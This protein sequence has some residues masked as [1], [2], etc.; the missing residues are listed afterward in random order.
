MTALPFRARQCFVSIAGT[1][2]F[3]PL[4]LFWGGFF[5]FSFTVF[6]SIWAWGFGLTA[7]WSQILAI[8]LSCFN[9]RKAA[10]WMLFN[11]AAS[12]LLAAGHVAW[13]LHG[14]V[15]SP[16]A[17]DSLLQTE[18]GLFKAGAI[19]LAPPLLFSILLLRQSADSCDLMRPSAGLEQRH[20]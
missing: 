11:T 17:F 4:Y 13:S 19:F 5:S 20:G 10:Y 3:L 18:S 1:L 2:L 9:P 7:C 16:G 14:N 6:N 12:V 15:E 8:L